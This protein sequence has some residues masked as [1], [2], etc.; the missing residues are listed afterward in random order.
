[1]ARDLL[2]SLIQQHTLNTSFCVIVSCLSNPRQHLETT[3]VANIP[4]SGK[5]E[6][7]SASAARGRVC[8]RVA[9]GEAYP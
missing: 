2:V 8:S 4:L 1:M 9:I 7:P 5:F 6:R 3:L